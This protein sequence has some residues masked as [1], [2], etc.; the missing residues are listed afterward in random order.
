MKRTIADET[1]I[2]NTSFAQQG[3]KPTNENVFEKETALTL[4]SPVTR[5]KKLHRAEGVVTGF[6]PAEGAAM[7]LNSYHKIRTIVSGANRS[8]IS[9]ETNEL[10]EKHQ[11][12]QTTWKSKRH[13]G[14]MTS[15]NSRLHSQET[16]EEGD[17]SA[18]KVKNPLKNG[19]N[20]KKNPPSNTK[21]V[22]GDFVPLATIASGD[23]YV[24]DNGLWTMSPPNAT[25]KEVHEGNAF[26][27]VKTHSP[28]GQILEKNS[29]AIEELSSELKVPSMLEDLKAETK[30]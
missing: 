13:R 14:E 21:N 11:N 7:R 15:S 25:I 28:S 19:I 30:I 20:N 5:R 16:F 9:G 23:A 2:T 27:E 12:N 18:L 4:H 22:D 6:S 1:M 3:A 24:D 29:S 17:Q 10:H 26:T 8:L